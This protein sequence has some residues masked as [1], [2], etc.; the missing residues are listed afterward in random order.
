M[1]MLT[2]E[3]EK[4]IALYGTDLSQW[5]QDVRDKARQTQKQ[6]GLEQLLEEYRA[7]ENTLHTR[8]I[9]PAHPSLAERIIANAKQR[10]RELPVKLSTWV[11]GL[12]ADFMIPSPAYALAAM[13]VLGVSIGLNTQNMTNTPDETSLTSAYTDDD[14]ATL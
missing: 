13:L 8:S 6:F 2:K 5:P 7:L 9:S 10:R 11:S 4:H 12:F 1:Y 14:G 3:F